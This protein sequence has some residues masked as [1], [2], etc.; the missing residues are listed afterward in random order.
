MS[1]ALF[2]YY[3]R[4]LLFV[5]DLTLE[6]ARQYPAA[7]A[8]LLIERNG[9]AD[10]HVERVIESFALLAG[11]LHQKL[12]DEFPELTEALLAVLSPHYLA[13]IPS[14]AVLQFELD[15]ARGQL[16]EGF[17]IAKHSRLFTQPV[18]D[19]PCKFRTGYPVTLWPVQLTAARLQ[20]PP[21][22]PGLQIPQGTRIEAILRLQF[23]AVG[24]LNFG[25]LALERLRL[26][27]HGDAEVIPLL[28][29]LLFNHAVEV[30]FSASEPGR[31][32]PP[33]SLKPAQALFQVG[34][35]KEESLLPYAPR[36]FLGY[37]L[38]TEFFAFPAKF[39]FLDLGGWKLAR[40]AGCTGD[41][42]EVIV[43]LNRTARNVEQAVNAATFRLGCAPV[44]NLFEPPP[45][46]LALTLGQHEYRIV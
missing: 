28:Y 18:E 43:F 17:L 16:P 8:R 36:S 7:A 6:F 42:V 26:Y 44:V 29:E 22:P 24:G 35:E 45:V 31:G 2:P 12:D 25:A 37:R 40:R 33:L 14:M 32:P 5:R 4:E 1:E 39:L 46:P 20:S 34:F 3:E 27:L 41:R 30:S 15:P 13:P 10:A 11:G 21:F 23:E 9:C 38:L 19:V